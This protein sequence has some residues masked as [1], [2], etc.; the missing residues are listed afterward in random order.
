MKATSFFINIGRGETVVEEDLI[1]ALNNKIISAAALDVFFKEPLSL[2]SPLW[3]VDNVIITPHVAGYTNQ[4]WPK[5]TNLFIKLLSN[6]LGNPI[7]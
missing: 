4:F 2:D 7:K 5:Q 6:H 1:F 3:D